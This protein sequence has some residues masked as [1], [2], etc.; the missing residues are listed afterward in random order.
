MCELPL[1][2]RDDF[3]EIGR[4]DARVLLY[5][6]QIAAVPHHCARILCQRANSRWDSRLRVYYAVGIRVLLGS[7]VVTVTV[8]GLWR[9]MSMENV[10]LAILAPLMPTM[11]WGVREIYRQM[12]A[13][14]AT[15]RLKVRANALWQGA[16]ANSCS[17]TECDQQSRQFQDALYIHRKRSPFVFDWVYVISRKRFERE[18]HASAEQMI[19]EAQAAKPPSFL[20]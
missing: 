10:V 19:N 13:A 14:A 11:L 1:G 8:V 20:R 3:G 6:T 2:L 16:L 5:P 4:F 17:E 15:E 18:M 12:D 7:I 9:Q